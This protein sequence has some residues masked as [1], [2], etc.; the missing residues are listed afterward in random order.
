MVTK[1]YVSSTYVDLVEFRKAARTV[2]RRLGIDDV[3]G[4]RGPDGPP[5]D[6]RLAAVA[7]SDLY[8][9]IFAWQYGF[10]PAGHT[11]SVTELEYRR[12]REL[13]KECLIFL[14]REDA[15]WPRRMM[16]LGAAAEP[17]D[18]L[19]RELTAEHVCRYFSDPEDL[20]VHL[21]DVV[22]R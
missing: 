20:A 7:E 2:L 6:E 3:S 22:T 19:R 15:R 4:Y 10:V 11:M 9:G 1:A 14:V 13:G 12:A 16:D 8:I 17:I 5:L 21:A 18:R